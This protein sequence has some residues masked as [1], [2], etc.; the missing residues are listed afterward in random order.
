MNFENSFEKI[1]NLGARQLDV[2]IESTDKPAEV[3][4]GKQ[5]QGAS[6]VCES[7]QNATH[8]QREEEL[9]LMMKNIM[10]FI[11]NIDLKSL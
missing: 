5:V 9:D 7:N 10:E 2:S 1:N 6:Q 8:K 11:R 3:L 4:P